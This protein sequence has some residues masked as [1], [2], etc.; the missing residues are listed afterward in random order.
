MSTSVSLNA[1]VRGRLT[2]SVSTD[3]LKSLTVINAGTFV[4]DGINVNG[5]DTD[6]R[7]YSSGELSALTSAMKQILVDELDFTIGT[8]TPGFTNVGGGSVGSTSSA[9]GSLAETWTITCT[10]ATVPATFSVSGSTTGLLDNSAVAGTAFTLGPLHFTVTASGAAFAVGDYFTVAV[11]L[12]TPSTGVA[13]SNTGNGTMGS[14]ALQAG[15]LK[16]I[17]TVT[18][19][20]ATN[21]TVVGSVSGAKAAATTGSAYNNGI[22]SFTITAGG[23]PFA[24]ADTFTVTVSGTPAGAA[25]GHTNSGNGTV[26]V[27]SYNNELA[28]V[29]TWTITMLSATTYS[30]SG[31][32]T[33]GT[34]NGDTTVSAGVYNNGIFHMTVTVGGSSWVAGDLFTITFGY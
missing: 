20:S 16:E 6:L 28:K 8:P 7:K 4:I 18:A 24:A 12:S 33:G 30:V 27:N 3:D 23:T 22:I 1:I 31:S 25:S 2:G 19:T 9:N 10:N 17:W 21:W 34:P 32:V 11:S 14:V 13:G 29:E 15:K 5:A 26:V